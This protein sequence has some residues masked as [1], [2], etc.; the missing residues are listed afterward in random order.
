MNLGSTNKL[1]TILLITITAGTC[2][3]LNSLSAGWTLGLF[4]LLGLFLLK[5]SSVNADFYLSSEE[6]RF[7]LVSQEILLS[8]QSIT[9]IDNADIQEDRYLNHFEMSKVAKRRLFGFIY[10]AMAYAFVTMRGEIPLNLN[11]IMP[12]IC[13]YLILRCVYVGHLM[14]PLALNI[15]S[16][17]VNYND[18][19]NPAFYGIYVFLVFWTLKAMSETTGQH[20]RWGRTIALIPIVILFV[21]AVYGMS[22]FFKDT[23][24][25]QK[26]TIPKEFLPAK[27]ALTR[28]K[29][30]SKEL[31]SEL[32][33]LP[34]VDTSQIE[35]KIKDQLDDIQ[36]L[37]K[38][39]E[40][41]KQLSQNLE[42]TKKMLES[43]LKTTEELKWEV[44]EAKKNSLEKSPTSDLLKD[45][46]SQHGKSQDQSMRE[47]I[48]EM[49]KNQD[50][51][52][53]MLNALEGK[54]P[55][56][57]EQNVI[58][59][60]KSKREMLKKQFEKLTEI[61]PVEKEELGNHLET[62]KKDL[63]IVKALMPD[64]QALKKQEENLNQLESL[65]N[66]DQPTP[67]DL[68]QISET[69]AESKEIENLKQALKSE[70]PTETPTNFSPQI[71]KP[72]DHPIDFD[73]KKLI[74]I[75]VFVGVFFI[76]VYF[77]NKKGIKKVKIL[78]PEALEEIKLELKKLKKLNLSPREEV[79]HYYNI[80][81]NILQTTHYSDHETPPSCI[82]YTEMKD[83]HPKLDHATLTVT[84][85][86]TKSF[87]GN[88]DVS[89][90]SLKD[91][92]K[93]ITIIMRVYDIN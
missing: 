69:L 80:L 10:L 86:F 71:T 64:N 91:F 45:F 62:K 58:E 56:N 16:L 9:T 18:Q 11:T 79:I 24:P 77:L 52:M 93:S 72:F 81:H 19:V 4:Y 75:V 14:L 42:S 49:D 46:E 63:A 68:R 17:I 32:Q 36:S 82:V 41:K 65:L 89:L 48:K 20:L 25:E 21:G 5:Y 61:S 66:K 31:L 29:H 38:T 73:F 43:V 40:S 27:Q 6:N 87:Y 3:V 50:K 83:F 37:Q 28:A 13:G 70:I 30:Q 74:P 88:K 67:A 15:C 90:P 60:L 85:L 51:L 1:F 26:D 39:M 8:G 34:S 23:S 59:D 84:E 54:G 78:S 44:G 7:K 2:L 92:R 53:Q 22:F 35:Q 47:L 76:A 57:E 55:T 33:K 12:I